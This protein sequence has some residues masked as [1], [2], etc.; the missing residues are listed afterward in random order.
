MREV[1][2]NIDLFKVQLLSLYFSKGLPPWSLPNKFCILRSRILKMF[3]Y[4]KIYILRKDKTLVRNSKR[5]SK[6]QN[7]VSMN[8]EYVGSNKFKCNTFEDIREYLII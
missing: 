6:L 2:K 8:S 7:S 3:R 1:I 4:T 5:K